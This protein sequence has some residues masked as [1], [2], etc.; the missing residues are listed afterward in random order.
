[1]LVEACLL[2]RL[3][4]MICSDAKGVSEVVSATSVMKKRA[5]DAAVVGNDTPGSSSY[6]FLVTVIANMRFPVKKQKVGELHSDDD[7]IFPSE[8]LHHNQPTRS[9]TRTGPP[10]TWHL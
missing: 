5:A 10:S 1:M 9:L 7:V 4:L 3:V 8:A 2:L 6:P